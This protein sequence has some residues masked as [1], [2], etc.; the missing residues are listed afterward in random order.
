MKKNR[1]LLGNHFI[2]YPSFYLFFFVVHTRVPVDGK[3]KTGF[4]KN[5]YYLICAVISTIII[6]GY[7]HQHVQTQSEK[8]LDMF[9][10]CIFLF[11]FYWFFFLSELSHTESI[12]Y[13]EKIIICW[14]GIKQLNKNNCL[15]SVQELFYLYFFLICFE[16]DK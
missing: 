15:W 5:I 8:I 12:E 14:Y 16:K 4:D 2:N 11:L 7:D 9:F 10:F 13:M 1:K 6:I 3:T